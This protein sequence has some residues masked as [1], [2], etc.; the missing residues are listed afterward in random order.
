MKKIPQILD[1]PYSDKESNVTIFDTVDVYPPASILLWQHST[2][3]PV[4]TL[5]MIYET[6]QPALG[7]LPAS[8][9]LSQSNPDESYNLPYNGGHICGS[10]LVRL[11]SDGAVQRRSTEVSVRYNTRRSLTALR[12]FYLQVLQQ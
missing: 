12:R 8:A 7:S 5:S 2:V 3:Y 11:L 4:I 1:M 9:E 6:R 10:A